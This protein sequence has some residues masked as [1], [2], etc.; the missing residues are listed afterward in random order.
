MKKKGFT[1]IELIV[2]IAIIAVLAAILIPAMLGF[3]KK[4]KITSANSAA[5]SIFTAAQSALTDMDTE[6]FYNTGKFTGEFTY[7]DCESSFTSGLAGGSNKTST[8]DMLPVFQ[9]KV[10]NYFTDITKL[11]GVGFSIKSGSCE[12]VVV[13]NGNYPGATPKQF[14]VDNYSSDT[15]Y[16][17]IMDDLLASAKN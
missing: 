12:A 14:I 7:K 6:D 3:I 15:T 5:K 17:D 13:V 4:S 10:Y 1:L 9:S 16:V 8:A 2:V 11:S